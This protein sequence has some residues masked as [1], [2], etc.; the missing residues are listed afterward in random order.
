M[1]N[2]FC[3][4]ASLMLVFLEDLQLGFSLF[5]EMVKHLILSVMV[6]LW[7]RCLTVEYV[8]F[9][10]KDM[11]LCSSCVKFLLAQSTR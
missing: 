2:S 11:S 3:G 1:L 10:D 6:V 5:A 7:W 8:C 4:Y 9:G